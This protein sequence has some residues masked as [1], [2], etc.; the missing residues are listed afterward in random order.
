MARATPAPARRILSL[1]GHKTRWGVSG[2][3]HTHRTR[4]S[5]G[6]L[7]ESG[8]IRS[9]S[10]ANGAAM[11]EAVCGEVGRGTLRAVRGAWA[12]AVVYDGGFWGRLRSV[13]V[14]VGQ[15]TA[16]RIFILE[17][18]VEMT[19]RVFGRALRTTETDHVPRAAPARL[20]LR[21]VVLLT[22]TRVCAWARGD[23]RGLSPSPSPGCSSR[24][25]V[26]AMA[27]PPPS[28]RSRSLPRMRTA[29]QRTTHFVCVKVHA[30]AARFLC[31]AALGRRQAAARQLAS[32]STRAPRSVPVPRSA[33]RPS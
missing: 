32:C 8:P 18:T 3:Q 9:H 1:S 14:A 11:F 29:G 16:T 19:Q 28:G 10:E 24:K 12:H 5:R 27:M 20:S 25:A 22:Q 21:S 30:P 31:V 15:G 2:R 17:G 13:A 26:A 33:G 4:S 7:G 23:A 6:I